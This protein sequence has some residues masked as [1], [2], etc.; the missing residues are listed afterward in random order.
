MHTITGEG[1]AGAITSV[2]TVID[3]SNAPS[4]DEQ[5]AID[6]FRTSSTNLLA[7]ESKAGVKHHI[8][9]SIVG[10]GSDRLPSVGYMAAKVVQEELIRQGGIP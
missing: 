5:S 9:M 10:V 6:I 2:D 3:L 4:F 7:A 8:A 1:L